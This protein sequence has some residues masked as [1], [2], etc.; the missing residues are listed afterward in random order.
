[1]I[2][3]AYGSNVFLWYIS[4]SLLSWG[5]SAAETFITWAANFDQFFLGKQYTSPQ[6]FESSCRSVSL[7]IGNHTYFKIVWV[8]LKQSSWNNIY[9]FSPSISLSLARAHPLAISFF[10]QQPVF[11]FLHM[12]I[13]LIMRLY[14]NCNVRC[15]PRAHTHK[16]IH[17]SVSTNHF[18]IICS[19]CAAN[20]SLGLHSK[21]HPH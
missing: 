20:S 19:I 12:K 13:G 21:S 2:Y 11:L 8:N 14:R 1:M 18:A 7:N 10:S 16:H 17:F 6:C 3:H 4:L 5:P 15:S 9:F